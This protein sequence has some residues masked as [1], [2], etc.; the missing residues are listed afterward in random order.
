MKSIS[1]RFLQLMV[2]LIGILAM[3]I[4]IWGPLTEGRATNLDLF[5]IYSDPLILFGYGVS[6]AFFVALYKGFKL[7][8]YIRQNRLYTPVSVKALKGIR[9]CA[10]ILGISILATG[11]FIMLFHG[12]EED[13]AGFLALCIFAIFAVVVV[14][15]VTAK[16]EKRLQNAVALNPE[17]E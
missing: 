12:E 4:L 3:V 14:T 16:F 10:I 11:L 15:I 13:P 8:G 5:S 1:I 7:L 9:Y 2:V 17:H 6:I